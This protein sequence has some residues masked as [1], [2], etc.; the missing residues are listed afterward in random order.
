MKS[1]PIG[2]HVMIHDMP[3]IEAMDKNTFDCV[4]DIL[5]G[6]VPDQYDVMHRA[7]CS[8]KYFK[9]ICI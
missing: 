7:Q 5:E 2:E 3:C 8:L 4:T 9:A 1:Y 6:K